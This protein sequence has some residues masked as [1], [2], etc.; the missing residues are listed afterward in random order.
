MAAAVL[1]GYAK[2]LFEIAIW[3]FSEC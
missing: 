3:A 2:K 1:P